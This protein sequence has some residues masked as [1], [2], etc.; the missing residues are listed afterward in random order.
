MPE[1][2]AEDAPMEQVENVLRESLQVNAGN[3]GV[4]ADCYRLQRD[5]VNA[6]L[7]RRAV[8]DGK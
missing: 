2:P 6:V 4:Y 1:L 3:H 8:D 7:R 5:L